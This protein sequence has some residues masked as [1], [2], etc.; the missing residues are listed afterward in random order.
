MVDPKVIAIG[1]FHLWILYDFIRCQFKPKDCIIT[2]IHSILQ[3]RGPRFPRKITF[4]K[5]IFRNGYR[6]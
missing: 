6:N 1:A 3:L 4:S 2:D 5:N